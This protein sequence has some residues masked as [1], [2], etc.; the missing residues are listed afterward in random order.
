MK[1]IERDRPPQDGLPRPEH[2]H[3][4]RRLRSTRSSAPTGD[5][6][7]TSTRSRS[8]TRRRTSC[9]PTGQT[10]GVFQFETR[11]MREILRKAKPQRFDDL[12]ALNALYRPGP[13]RRHGRRL[14]RRASRARP[15]STYEVPQ[16]EPILQD[17]YGVIAY[18]EQ[19]M[20]IARDAGRLLAG[21]S[22][23]AAQGH[24]QEEPRGHGK[25]QRE[26]RRG[27]RRERASPRR[28]PTQIFDLMEHFAG[29]GFNKS[30]STTY[31]LL[32]YQTGLPQGELP[33]ALHGGAADD[34][35]AEHRQARA[36]PRRVP[37]AAACRCC[38][39]T[40]TR[41][42]LRVHGRAARASA[43]A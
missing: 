5:R 30:H 25:A 43:S 36:V 21:R 38:R 40:S 37:R 24:G 29:Y 26:V 1:E 17:T 2:A 27:R 19:V 9:S 34:R 35:V 20:R 13:L 7:S 8:T 41:A 3:A 33:V 42:Q 11:G 10:Y 6:R 22:R 12:I 4:D 14:H 28:R 31:A 15:R 18:Q 32:A 23:P 39:P 16:L